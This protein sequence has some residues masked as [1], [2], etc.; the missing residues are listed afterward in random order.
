MKKLIVG[1]LLFTLS[2]TAFAQSCLESS[3]AICRGSLVMHG[4]SIRKVE[5]VDNSGRVVLE[6]NTNY[7]RTFTN[8]NE[9]S[10]VVQCY[11]DF[12]KGDK[13]LHGDSVRTIEAVS[14]KG[15]VALQETT[16]YYRTFTT[17]SN[18]SKVAECEK[19][20]CV[21]NKVI[22]GNSVREIES[23]DSK[24]RV[25][26]KENMQYYRTFTRAKEVGKIVN[27]YDSFC[28]GDEVLHGNS[29]RKIEF[30]DNKGRAVLKETMQYYRTFVSLSD[31]S[32]VQ[33]CDTFDA[34]DRS[35][36]S[37]EQ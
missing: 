17:V 22:H 11:V 32:M 13:V 35:L 34:R 23:L 36:S 18:I 20:L 19:G 33:E 4:D 3:D 2:A 16:Q 6:E 14:N 37:Y 8:K 26:L 29:I 28:S 24:G 21:G 9:V 10:K 7:Y 1:S 30:V 15:K 12:C 31:I 27:C 25:V 5:A